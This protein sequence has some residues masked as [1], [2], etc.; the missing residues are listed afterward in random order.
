M[1]PINLDQRSDQ[2]KWVAVLSYFSLPGWIIALILN[3][4]QRTELGS[5]HIRQSLGW[6]IAILLLV[7]LVRYKFL[8]VVLQLMGSI[9][10]ILTALKGERRPLPLVGS[11]FQEWFRT[12]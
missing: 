2:G 9:F 4:N 11:Y 10:G 8:V 6:M 1:E 5:F 7:W 3:S 12:L